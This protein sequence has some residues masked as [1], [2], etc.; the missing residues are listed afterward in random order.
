[1]ADPINPSAPSAPR[2]A[3]DLTPTLTEADVRHIASLAQL[4]PTDEQIAGYRSSLAAILGY[5]DRLKALDLTGVE[6]LI[7]PLAMTGPVATDIP[8]TSLTR[9]AM[10]ALAP[11]VD[12]HFISVPKVLADGGAA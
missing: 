7:T 8:S 6:P 11:K 5:V 10:L 4:A 1:M 3:A 2:A 9:D 12:G